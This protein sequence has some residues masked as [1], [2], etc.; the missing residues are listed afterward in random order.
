VIAK[1][2]A[3]QDSAP[4][5]RALVSALTDAGYAILPGITAAAASDGGHVIEREP[6]DALPPYARAGLIPA[7]LA[8]TARRR[9]AQRT[10][11]RA[12]LRVNTGRCNVNP[13]A[14]HEAAAALKAQRTANAK[15]Y[16]TAAALWGSRSDAFS[17]G[18]SARYERIART[19]ESGAL[20]HVVY[21]A[22]SLPRR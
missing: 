7:A 9:R 2:A 1:V 5:G 19:I 14:V 17:A 16:R 13:D 18:M 3:E 15:R 11:H 8:H 12:S 10:A 21:A 22:P 20:G 6:V 4:V